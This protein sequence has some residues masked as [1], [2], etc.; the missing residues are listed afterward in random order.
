MWKEVVLGGTRGY[1]G[2]APQRNP[3]A[4]RALR[5][6]ARSWRFLVVVV[7]VVDATEAQWC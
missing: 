6:K 1:V 7:V 4:P 5:V 2:V 3:L